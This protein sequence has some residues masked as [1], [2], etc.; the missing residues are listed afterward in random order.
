[1]LRVR[2]GTW[3]RKCVS[4]LGGGAGVGPPNGGAGMAL[5]GGVA[6]EESPAGRLVPLA[7][8]APLTVCDQDFC[9]FPGGPP[10]P[11][12]SRFIAAGASEYCGCGLQ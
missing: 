10:P 5:P 12:P 8:F 2:A 9:F 6:W 4:P 11:L 1:M 7:V 3:R